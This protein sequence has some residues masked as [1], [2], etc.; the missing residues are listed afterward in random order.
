MTI[1]LPDD[2]PEAVSKMISFLY[3]GDYDEE[4]RPSYSVAQDRLV[5]ASVRSTTIQGNSEV[6]NAATHQ[7]PGNSANEGS[8]VAST[9]PIDHKASGNIRLYLL[10]DKYDIQPLKNLAKE[11][12]KKWA[13]TH[14]GD[15]TFPGVVR[16]ILETVPEHDRAL[17]DI[18]DELIAKYAEPLLLGEKF[19]RLIEDYK[20]IGTK[21]MIQIL[22]HKKEAEEKLRRSKKNIRELKQ[23]LEMK[24]MGIATM[25]KINNLGCCESCRT[26]FNLKVDLDLALGVTLKCGR[27][28]F[29]CP[30]R[31]EQ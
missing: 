10:A 18:V 9:T 23:D 31:T 26:S 1:K 14:W 21:I 20:I 28:H 12:F 13:Q 6:I 8:A 17:H 4:P 22:E 30:S 27:C 16:E 3:T 29:V 2:D 5:A 15:N 11:K 24:E 7:T 25:T 19:R